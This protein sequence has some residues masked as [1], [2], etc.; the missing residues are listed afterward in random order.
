M[1][2]EDLTAYFSFSESF[3]PSQGTDSA[4]NTFDP[5][6]GTAYE[7]GLKY[8][9]EDGKF[10]ATLS[11]FDIR[12]ENVLAFD[13]ADPNGVFLINSGKVGSKGVELDVSGQITDSFRITSALTWI[14]AEVL[15]SKTP[16][17]PKGS[18]LLNIPGFTT[19]V[20]GIQEFE[21]ARHGK[22]GIG[23]GVIYVA[24]RSGH[25][26]GNLRLPDYT[27]MKALTYWQYNENLQFTLDIDNLLGETYY[28]SSLNQSVVYPGSPRTVTL[29]VTLT[30]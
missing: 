10:G 27:T 1:P 17:I 30:F 13:P 11:V 2:R 22:I 29:G 20:L 8:Q 28:T 3:R 7:L 9:R 4:F 21:L 14:D 12:K 5:E 23:A 25:D 19:S 6:E 18:D 16:A 26:G 15:E 24:D